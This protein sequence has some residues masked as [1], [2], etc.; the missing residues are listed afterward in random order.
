M[1]FWDISGPSGNVA[2]N[3]ITIQRKGQSTLKSKK[4]ESPN[5]SQ[6]RYFQIWKSAKIEKKKFFRQRW[7][8]DEICLGSK[9]QVL[10]FSGLGLFWSRI[11]KS[12]TTPGA[13]LELFRFFT[14]KSQKIPSHREQFYFFCDF[15]QCPF[16]EISPVFLWI[17]LSLVKPALMDMKCKNLCL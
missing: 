12:Q 17:L 5:S 7:H 1:T 14:R 10:G 8:R 11:P 13:R 3:R 2:G 4:L 9:S 15:Y 6:I 16:E